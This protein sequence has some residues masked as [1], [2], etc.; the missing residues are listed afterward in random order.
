MKSDVLPLG[1]FA[2]PSFTPAAMEV[3]PQQL[4][5]MLVQCT[6]AVLQVRC[7]CFAAQR[8]QSSVS[9]KNSMRKSLLL[10]PCSESVPVKLA[11]PLTEMIRRWTHTILI[12]TS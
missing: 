3:L 10:S 7:G 9:V 6:I 8:H 11:E 5:E 12:R 2:V 1:A 4:Q